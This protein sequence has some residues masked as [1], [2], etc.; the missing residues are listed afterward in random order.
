M[1]N[2]WN[3][4]CGCQRCDDEAVEDD[5]ERERLMREE[6]PKIVVAT[7]GTGDIEVNDTQL[8]YFRA[9][10]RG[11]KKAAKRLVGKDVQMPDSSK[12][13]SANAIRRA[14]C[15]KLEKTYRKD[16]KAPKTTLGIVY[17]ETQDNFG[18]DYPRGCRNAVDVSDSTLIVRSLMAGLQNASPSQWR[19]ALY[20]SPTAKDWP[21]GC[22]PARE[23]D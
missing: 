5:A 22:G 3:F 20:P 6:W 16:R 4:E 13:V 17:T 18:P 10:F 19:G 1:K 2:I 15:D 8:D 23:W 11:D 21:Q 9:K 7:A 14:F 12:Q